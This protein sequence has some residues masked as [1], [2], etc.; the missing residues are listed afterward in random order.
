MTTDEDTE[1][2]EPNG[3]RPRIVGIGAS[4]G[5]LEAIEALVAQITPDTGIAWTVVQHLSPDHDSIMDRLLAGYTGLPVE[6]ITDGLR[7]EPD[8]IYLMPAGFEVRLEDDA[9]RLTERFEGHLSTPIDVFFHSLASERGYDAFGIV[10]SGTGSDG[11]NGIKAIK[12]AG[13][14]AMVQASDNARFPGMPDSARSTGLVDF[15]LRARD[16]PAKINEIARHRSEFSDENRRER[17][18]KE[19]EDRL[20][21][22]TEH[23]KNRHG[24][25]FTSYKPGTLVRR[26]ERRMSLL[27]YQTVDDYLEKLTEEESEDALLLQDFLIGVTRFFRDAEFFDLLR[28]QVVRPLLDSEQKGFRVWVPGC[29]TGEEAYSIALIFLE[30]MKASNDRRPLQVFGT[31]IDQPALLQARMGAYAPSAMQDVPE[32]LL[33]TWFTLENGLYRAKPSLR[34]ICVFA[35]HNLLQDPPF[36]RLDLISC[37]NLMIYLDSTLQRRVIP[38]FHFALRDGGCLFLGPAEGLAG[39]D[40][41]FDVIENKARIFRRNDATPPRYS[42]LTS[43]KPRVR[44][45]I[46]AVQPEHIDVQQASADNRA[47]QAF[48]SMHAAPF[49]V[50]SSKGEVSYVSDQMARLVQPEKGTPSTNIDSYLVRPLRLPVRS[51]LSEARREGSQ[52]TVLNVVVTSEKGEEIYDVL[53]DPLDGDEDDFLVT[54]KPVKTRSASE[55]AELLGEREKNEGRTLERELAASR[56]QLELAEAEFDS[57]SQRLQ[58]TNEELLSMNE[59]L[60][61][62]NEELE[63]SREELQSI[64]EELE[65]LNAELSENNAQL[66]RA[67]SDVKNLFESTDIAVL[68]LDSQLSV[69]SFTPS[70]SHLFGIRQRDV[71]RPI[72]DLSARVEYPE[73]A[74]DAERVSQ[75]LQR[76]QREVSISAT[77]ETFILRMRPY[78]TTDDRLDGYVLTFVDITERKRIEQQ[79]EENAEALA[80]QYAELESL[81]DTTPVGLSLIDRD[82]R[83]LRINKQLADIHGFPIEEHIGK[84]QDE[85]LPETDE[86]F[87]NLQRQVLR[88]GEAVMNLEVQGHT[89]ADP[90]TLRDWVIDY[91][92]VR[93][94]SGD[95]F[96]VGTCVREVTEQK[97]LLRQVEASEARKTILLGELQ[98]RVKNTLAT[99]AAISRFSATGV[100]TV[101]DYQERLGD[102]L[103][104]ISRTHDLL[105]QT[106]WQKVSLFDI[107][108]DEMAPYG[109]EG[110]D[111]YELNGPDLTLDPREALAL[112]LAFHE[113]TTNAAKYGA[114]SVTDGCVRINVTVDE[115]DSAIFNRRIEWREEG[116]PSVKAPEGAGFGSFLIGEVLG[117]QTGGK[118]EMVFESDGLVV[119]IALP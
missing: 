85:L 80:R 90:D 36:S 109:K 116:G 112:G 106:D 34:E 94:A 58:A 108:R 62:S 49:A 114:L 28:K 44:T 19:I 84:R 48:L 60:Q 78:R 67:N 13:G 30:E 98:H 2:P 46:M 66:Q 17:L 75:T 53:V 41:F 38:R 87:A 64:N 91:Y 29:S 1:H 10:L 117:A 43:E 119:R 95:V 59:E 110:H 23:L 15:V 37:R 82:L 77:N 26:I 81:Y 21:A 54:L 76:V 72:S 22:F 25:D 16:M 52:A 11:T 68:F 40:E 35:P 100:E 118:A 99:V 105:T 31:D 39:H 71:G 55:V 69:R 83:W 45:N 115:S 42:P 50:V 12:A 32:E 88:T 107:L 93:S 97:E 74:E 33:D 96:A 86:K 104:A 27:R 57:S 111:C 65:T 14:I 89:A 102:R 101:Q 6:T 51:A 92:P 56:R 113:L 103:V 20:P 73:L 79:L 18:M 7:P 70:T 9:F 5:G 4:A 24:H 61:S 47:E 63:T 8:K 3:D